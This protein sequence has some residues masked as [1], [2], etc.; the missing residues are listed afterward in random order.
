MSTSFATVALFVATL[1]VGVVY[2]VDVFFAVIGRS[3]LA[4]T[5]NASLVDVMG[6]LHAVADARMP[7]F[8]ATSI[9]ATLAFVVLEGFAT[10]GGA[11]GLIALLA[12]LLHLALYLAVARPIN[13]QLS[14]AAQ[15]GADL[16]EGRALQQRWNQIIGWRALLLLTAFGCLLGAGFVF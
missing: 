4:R 1:T 12:L 6:H 16:P 10:P 3:A 7:I 5:R 14:Y 8:G 11:L 13:A 2:G 15:Q 9:V